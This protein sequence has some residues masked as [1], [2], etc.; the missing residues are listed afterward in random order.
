[1]A[2]C[3][4][5]RRKRPTTWP[6]PWSAWAA[7]GA[8]RGAQL[9]HSHCGEGI[10]SPQG[11]ACTSCPAGRDLGMA[12]QEMAQAHEQLARVLAI[13]ARHRRTDVVAQHL[14]DPLRTVVLM[15]QVMRQRCGGDLGDV[16]VLGDRQHL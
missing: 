4:T 11:E 9:L 16:L 14:L 6:S 5:R 7:C 15:Q 3:P 1:M 12:R 8:E 13:V 2:F 10:P